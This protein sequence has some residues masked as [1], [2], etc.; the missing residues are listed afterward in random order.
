MDFSIKEKDDPL[1]L[2]FTHNVSVKKDRFIW[3]N[4]KRVILP[5]SKPTNVFWS[6]HLSNMM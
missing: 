6:K 5:P 1:N 4:A 2:D 3:D